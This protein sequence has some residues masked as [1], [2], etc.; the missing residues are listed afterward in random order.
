MVRHIQSENKTGIIETRS[1]EDAGQR[2]KE[3]HILVAEQQHRRISSMDFG[4]KM[5]QHTFWWQNSSA[6]E[7]AA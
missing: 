2:D 3:T 7:S 5:T 4:K 6:G 1:K